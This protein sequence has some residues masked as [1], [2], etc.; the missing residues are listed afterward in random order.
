MGGSKQELIKK[1]YNNYILIL[2]IFILLLFT[3]NFFSYEES[4]IYGGSDGQ[5]YVSIS[6][7]APFFGEGIE[8]IKGERFLVP[9]QII[10]I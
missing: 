6:N 2:F 8:Y 3:N 4:L 1:K 9:Y 5:Y 7:Y 10:L